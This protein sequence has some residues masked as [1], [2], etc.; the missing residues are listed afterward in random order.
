VKQQTRMKPR[1]M[2][3]GGGRAYDDARIGLALM[4]SEGR[5]LQVNPRLCGLLGYTRKQLLGTTLG[6]VIDPLDQQLMESNSRRLLAGEID[7]FQSEQHFLHAD[8]RHF[9]GRFS[10]SVTTGVGNRSFA[11]VLEIDE[12]GERGA[13]RTQKDGREAFA[14]LDDFFDGVLATDESGRIACFNQAASRLFGYESAEV[15]G[16]EAGLIIAGPCQEE[17]ADFL[18]GWAR[19]GGEAASSRPREMWG[20]RKDGSTFPIEIRASRMLLG[21]EQHLVAI[22][23]DIS[24]Q[25]AQTEALEYQT[26][27]DVLTNLPNRV[28]LNDRLHQAILA[29]SRQRRTAALLILDVDG[30]KEVNDTCGHHTGDLLLQ[31]IALRLE[32]LLRSSDT[33]A[34]L[35]GDEFAILPGLGI[36]GE[37]G[38]RTAQKVL[39]VMEQPFMIDGRVL[40][41]SA[42]IGIALFPAHGRDASSLMRHADEA[43][44]VAKRA[45][46]G[47][48]FHVPR[49]DAVIPEHRVQRGELGHA[50]EHD[51]MVLHFQPTIDLRI[52]R[53]IGVE[54]L[55]RWQH[56]EQGLL[57]PMSFIPV[58]EEAGLIMPLTRWVL[59]RA[60]QQA[61]AWS[62]AGLDIDVAVNLSAE[63]LR[64]PGLPAM[65]S[66]LLKVW[67]VDP[68]R[69]KA[70]LPESSVMAPPAVETATRLGAMGIGLA[71]DD[72]GADA[73][74][75]LHLARLPVREVKIDGAR[76]DDSTLRPIVDQG[77]RMGFRMAA[78]RVEDQATLDR[79]RGLGCDSAQGFHLCPPIVAADLAPWLRDSA[80]GLAERVPPRPLT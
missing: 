6:A 41:I 33:V 57:L 10:A 3:G 21:G 24:E 18:A 59:N 23:R 16:R 22:L 76:G 72:F 15:V 34:R 52:G 13:S 44:Y 74:S 2:R 31:Q 28:L 54:A 79:L 25:K 37:D 19:F 1:S 69:L 32:G 51:Q 46:S 48:A 55:V 20:R 27:H 53:T 5:V 75:L 4:S 49:Q 70:D 65:T 17:F 68:G 39:R 77:H 7:E 26:L 9:P 47:Y 56:P 58:A 8:G 11:C 12:P 78:K 14:V 40:R 80:W 36:G 29:G 45:R 38:A 64:D 61:R 30:F 71:I 60:L 66:E 62:K 67:R 63:S 42:S 35:G 50:I 43:M 73:A